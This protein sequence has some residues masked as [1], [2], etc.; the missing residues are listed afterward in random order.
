MGPLKGSRQR[1][2]MI[3]WQ[4]LAAVCRRLKA[5]VRVEGG[6]PLGSHCCYPGQEGACAWAGIV[7]VR[8]DG[9]WIFYSD[10]Y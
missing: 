1:V 3:S 4:V 6:N 5:G 2:D 10:L 9:F 7:M 8:R